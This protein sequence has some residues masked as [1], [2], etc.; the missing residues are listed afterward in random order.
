MASQRTAHATAWSAVDVF[1][2]QGVQF[3]VTVLLAR[4]LTPADFGAIVLMSLF[5]GVAL[6]VAEAGVTTSI[7]QRPTVT[8]DD[9]TT[10]LWLTTAVAVVMAAALGLAGPLIADYYDSPELRGLAVVLAVNVVIASCGFVPTALLQRE[11]DFRVIAMSGAFA[12]LTSGLLAV[13][14]AH[15]GAGVWALAGQQLALSAVG[16]AL[17]WLMG[18]WRPRG[19]ITRA[20]S[21]ALLRSG[22]YV[23]PANL[24]DIVFV[25]SYTVLIGRSYG[26]SDVG[27]YSRADQTQQLPI[28]MLSIIFGRVALPLFSRAGEDR[29]GLRS[30][31]RR[32]VRCLMWI[33]VPMM[34]GLAVTAEPVVAVLFGPRWEPAGPIFAVL[35]LAG[36][37]WPL[38]VINLQVLVAQGELRLF[39]RLEVAKKVVGITLIVLGAQ[40]GLT[41]LAWSQVAFGVLAFLANAHYTRVL[42]GYGA[43][44]Q[45]YDVA[46]G[47]VG[48]VVVAGAALVVSRAWDGSPAVELVTVLGGGAA[49]YV[50]LSWAFGLRAWSDVTSVARA[51]LRKEAA[52]GADGDE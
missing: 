23:M 42:V 10:A 32:A 44:R 2:R 30:S 35:C 1:A 52:V 41:G 33:N 50:L 24:L 19:R 39:F 27:Y 17:V 9:T 4:L 6:T 40:L 43:L 20:T 13:V 46:A 28:Q 7:V 11:L 47:A 21:E 12:S 31:A 5:T 29:S 37:L 22:R 14:L 18:G 34:L 3:A 16:T 15:Q 49:V 25:R 48:A 36:V 38:H 51:A 26:V 8:D 45:L